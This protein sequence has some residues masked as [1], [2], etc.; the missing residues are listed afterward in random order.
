MTYHPKSIMPCA[1]FLATKTENHYT[2]LKT[3]A[4]KVPKTTPEDVIAAEML[5]IQGLRFTLDVRHPFRALEGGIMELLA[6]ADG[7]GGLPPS[8]QGEAD[9]VRQAFCEIRR[10]DGSTSPASTEDVK[11]RIR[12]AHGKAKDMLKTGAQLTDAYFHYTPAHIWLASL[13]VADEPLALFFLDVKLGASPG[14]DTQPIKAKLTSTL[15]TLS[16]LLQSASASMELAELKRIDKKLFECRNPE[17]MDLVGLNRAQKR[18]G[19]ADGLSETA[20]KKRRLERER[21]EREGSEVFGGEL[22]K[23]SR[24]NS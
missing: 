13:L 20:M 21:G 9:A 1:L 2:S 15:H 17:K 7:T 24:S 6:L 16:A 18:E 8:R 10:R 4:S 23:S 11:N 5:I 22:T 12:E 19:L 3:F 14:P